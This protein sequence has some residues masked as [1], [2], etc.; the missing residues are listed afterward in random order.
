MNLFQIYLKTGFHVVFE[1][2]SEEALVFK[3]KM[4]MQHIFHLIEL[5]LYTHTHTQYKYKP[6]LC[7]GS[8][9]FKSDSTK[10]W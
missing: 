10:I 5:A 6:T 3:R 9:F 8:S 7:V 2:S 1:S 4:S